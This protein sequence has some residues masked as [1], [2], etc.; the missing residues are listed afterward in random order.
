MKNDLK[1]S[2]SEIFASIDGEGVRTGMLTSFIRLN[3]CNLRCNYC[4]TDYSLEMQPPNMTLDEIL[5]RLKTYGYPRITLTGGEPLI[6][7]NVL[8]L[9]N[10]LAA[11]GYEVNIE[12]NGAVPLDAFLNIPGVFFTMDWK[13]PDSGAHN[14]MR[15][16]NLTLLTERDVLKFVV[17]SQRDLEEFLNIYNLKLPCKYYISPVWGRIEPVQI[18]AFMQ[19]HKTL[20][21]VVQVQL[22]KIIW[23][24]DARGV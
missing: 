3:G 9:L 20:N 18:V 5:A 6:H 12:T 17:S 8:E 22:H 19:Q 10:S 11:G 24:P 7:P 21:A 4:D 23:S 15:R 14:F 1:Y 13:C 16:E 2:V